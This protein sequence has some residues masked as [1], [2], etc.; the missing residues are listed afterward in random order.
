V[1]TVTALIVA[2]AGVR[3][4]AAAENTV[5]A[6]VGTRLKD[7][8]KL[9]GERKIAE[10]LA[11]AKEALAQAKTPFETFKANE[12][13]AYIDLKANDA[14]GAVHSYEAIIDSQYLDANSRANYTKTLAQ[15]YFAT[16]GYAKAIEYGQR[17]LKSTPGDVDFIVLV[18]QAYFVQKDCKS[19]S[20]Y[21]DQAVEASQAAGRPVKENYYL[22]KLQ[23]AMDA[24]NIPGQIDVLD[25]LVA[26][27]PKKEHWSRLLSLAAREQPDRT[28]QHFYRLKFETDTLDTV[29]EYVEMA[30]LALQFGYPGE[31]QAVLERGFSSKVLEKDP[32]VAERNRRLLESAK[33]DAEAD[34]KTLPLQDKEAR[35]QKTGEADVKLGFAYLTYG[36]ATHAVE[37]LE[38][39]IGKGGVKS[40]AEAQIFLGMAYLKANRPEDA[41]RAFRGAKDDQLLGAVAKLWIIRADQS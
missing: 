10:A 12:V 40:P 3:T 5:S 4:A 39:G 25:D 9:V 22:I 1:F 17:V 21:M 14:Q 19:A 15:L 38:R 20:R 36:D 32:A 13:L 29:G 35:N 18:G 2:G 6:A 16:R 11:K 33:K 30:Q 23:C 24:Q 41:K 8:T 34:K 27:F 31:A 28:T 37:A 7:A 26:R